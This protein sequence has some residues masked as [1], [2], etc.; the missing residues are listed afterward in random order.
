[1]QIT[2]QIAP[3]VTASFGQPNR[4]VTAFER[5][6]HPTQWISTVTQLHDELIR[7][8]MEARLGH[9]SV[10]DTKSTGGTGTATSVP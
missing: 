2:D 4:Q 10:I 8:R 1:M 9:L 3:W 7:V 5:W 6:Q